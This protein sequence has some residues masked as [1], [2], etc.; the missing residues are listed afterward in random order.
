[1]AA[2]AI[3]IIPDYDWYLTHSLG[4]CFFFCF[5]EINISSLVF[6]SPDVVPAGQVS[7][8]I[9]QQEPDALNVNE[10]VE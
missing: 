2:F 10:F 9:L 4:T 7:V 8:F 6:I 3:Q 1:M 5:T